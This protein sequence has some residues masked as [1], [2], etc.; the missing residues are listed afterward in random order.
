MTENNGGSLATKFVAVAHAISRLD[1]GGLKALKNSDEVLGCADYWRISSDL[2]LKGNDEFW[3]AF[4]KAIAIL[5]SWAETPAQRFVHSPGAQ[6]GRIMVEND[7][8]EMRFNRLIHLDLEARRQGVL[9][10]ISRAGAGTK[11]NVIQIGFLLLSDSAT[12]IRDLSR[13]YYDAQSYKAKH[14]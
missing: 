5:T 11:V 6:L 4:C 3:M 7:V 1:P 13:Q 8:T 9:G 12:S 14:G 2:K 10:L